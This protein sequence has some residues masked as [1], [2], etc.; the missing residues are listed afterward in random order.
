MQKIRNN[1]DDTFENSTVKSSEP[2]EPTSEVDS[3]PLSVGQ[4][5]PQ[6]PEAVSQYQE[7]LRGAYDSATGYNPVDEIRYTAGPAPG[8]NSNPSLAGLNSA[9]ASNVSSPVA[10]VEDRVTDDVYTGFFQNAANGYI[11][12]TNLLRSPVIIFPPLDT[13]TQR[14]RLQDLYRKLERAIE[15]TRKRLSD[16]PRIPETEGYDIFENSIDTIEALVKQARNETLLI[17]R[18]AEA[19]PEAQSLLAFIRSVSMIMNGSISSSRMFIIFYQS[20]ACD[21]EKSFIG[22]HAYL[23]QANLGLVNALGNCLY[24][25]S[26]EQPTSTDVLCD[27]NFTVVREA[28][29]PALRSHRPIELLDLTLILYPEVA[30]LQE[31]LFNVRSLTAHEVQ[32][33]LA[34]LQ[35]TIIRLSPATLLPVLTNMA[36]KASHDSAAQQ[37]LN[38]AHQ[39]TIKL[40]ASADSINFSISSIDVANPG[41][42]TRELLIQ[43]CIG[44]GSSL[45]Q[46]L[47]KLLDLSLHR[48]VPKPNT[49]SRSILERD[50]AIGP[51]VSDP[52]A[53]STDSTDEAN[54]GTSLGHE[55]HGGTPCAPTTALGS[56]V[57]ELIGKFRNITFNFAQILKEVAGELVSICDNQAEAI[58]SRNPILLKRTLDL[59]KTLRDAADEADMQI[60]ATIAAA[61]KEALEE[62]RVCAL[63]SALRDEL[64]VVFN[65]ASTLTKA[66]IRVNPQAIYVR[67]LTITFKLDRHCKLLL[68]NTFIIIGNGLAD[69]SDGTNNASNITYKSSRVEDTENLGVIVNVLPDH[70][71]TAIGGDVLN[72]PF[73]SFQA[74]IYVLEQELTAACTA[75]ANLN[76]HPT[77]D[78]RIMLAEW[79][80]I[81]KKMDSVLEEYRKHA[82][83]INHPEDRRAFIATL[84]TLS[85]GLAND[86]EIISNV[87]VDV[88]NYDP[89]RIHTI[90]VDTCNRLRKTLGDIIKRLR[91]L[92]RQEGG[93]YLPAT[94]GSASLSKANDPGRAVS[95]DLGL[96]ATASVSG[97]GGTTGPDNMNAWWR[98][99][100]RLC[101]WC[102]GNT[103]DT[104]IS[105]E[106]LSMLFSKFRGISSKRYKELVRAR[107]SLSKASVHLGTRA[108]SLKATT[109]ILLNTVLISY[110][111]I[112]AL[113][114][115]AIA[116]P[117]AQQL[118]HVLMGQLQESQGGLYSMQAIIDALDD[119]EVGND[120][121][122]Y[123]HKSLVADCSRIIELV[124]QTDGKLM[125]LSGNSAMGT[126]GTIDNEAA[127]SG[128]AA[129]DTALAI[130][131]PVQTLSPDLSAQLMSFKDTVRERA[132]SM[133][134]LRMLLDKILNRPLA[135]VG[136]MLTELRETIEELVLI[137]Q[138]TDLQAQ[139]S[140]IN[141]GAGADTE[142]SQLIFAVREHLSALSV[143]ID[144]A[145]ELL[146]IIQPEEIDRGYDL[147]L[148]EEIISYL[149]SS[150]TGS[151]EQT[152]S[153][154][155]DLSGP[156]DLS[157]LDVLPAP[158][159]PG[160]TV[161]STTPE[162]LPEAADTLEAT[163]SGDAASS[164]ASGAPSSSR[165][166][167]V[168]SGSGTASNTGATGTASG[169]GAASGSG[170]SGGDGSRPP[171][172]GAPGSYGYAGPST[173]TISPVI[174]ILLKFRKLARA[175]AQKLGG[176]RGELAYYI[177]GARTADIEAMAPKL[178]KIIREL[179]VELIGAASHADRQSGDLFGS[180]DLVGVREPAARA[181]AT[182]LYSMLCNAIRQ[183]LTLARTTEQ[184]SRDG[185]QPGSIDPVAL[186]ADLD[187][188]ILH[189]L[190]L[191]GTEDLALSDET[192]PIPGS[193]HVPGTSSGSGT[194]AVVP[195][196]IGSSAN[197][198][199]A[200]VRNY[201]RGIV[202]G[203]RGGSLDTFIA[204]FADLQPSEG[205]TMSEE[206]FLAAS[207]LAYLLTYEIIVG[208]EE[209]LESLE[210]V[211]AQ[212]MFQEFIGEINRLANIVSETEERFRYARVNDE[213]ARA[214]GLSIS[215]IISSTIQRLV[216]LSSAASVSA[217]EEPALIPGNTHVPGTSSSYGAAVVDVSES[218]VGCQ[219]Q[220]MRFISIILDLCEDEY[221]GQA[222]KDLS[223]LI[224]CPPS[225]LQNMRSRLR[226]LLVNLSEVLQ[227]ALREAR[228]YTEHLTD[229]EAQQMT[230]AVISEIETLIGTLEEMENLVNNIDLSPHQRNLTALLG[231]TGTPLNNRLT[232]TRDRLR[233]LMGS[234]PRTSSRA[235]ISSSWWYRWRLC[236]GTPPNPHPIDTTNASDTAASLEELGRYITNAVMSI[237]ITHSA[238]SSYPDSSK[239]ASIQRSMRRLAL[240]LHSYLELFQGTLSR[241]DAVA[242]P[243]SY[244]QLL[245]IIQE[246]ES[247]SAVV[248]PLVEQL[249]NVAVEAPGSQA[250]TTHT[251]ITE[252]CNS[253]SNT[254]EDT[255]NRLLAL[256][257]QG[258][259]PS[260]VTVLPPV[261]TNTPE[262]LPGTEAS[263]P[264]EAAS[265]STRVA[266]SVDA[267]SPGSSSEEIPEATAE[268]DSD[269]NPPSSPSGDEN[270]G[271]DAS[272]GSS[273]DD[274]TRRLH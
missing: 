213:L 128:S 230:A 167:G 163:G 218:G 28:F 57:C 166:T 226:N 268:Q 232:Q 149:S 90:M 173:N 12:S 224:E 43:A 267:S 74:L 53:A 108:S 264:H 59:M 36:T 27:D 165:G 40:G 11:G 156:E 252:I 5:H 136:N 186:I 62:E 256:T 228:E 231:S 77:T 15:E 69:A 219:A 137:M 152:I 212:Q 38:N 164:S 81:K 148:S 101:A 175:L 274:A 216:E 198:S 45:Q 158:A 272:G 239:L 75:L 113:H 79:E 168:N 169:A 103:R 227:D 31:P 206:L 209:Y 248:H 185:S 18:N 121:V 262:V 66:L 130:S 235:G 16:I 114:A 37:L 85:A 91:T 144:N 210:D 241:T 104:E 52:I 251:L 73:L 8:S 23:M 261:T 98:G 253:L 225:S 250:E 39:E 21:P 243:D 140:L 30:A 99:W 182:A 138:A 117:E 56:E 46:T 116:S 6:L 88:E 110:L 24:K 265:A 201:I 70:D 127:D 134:R 111:Q 238:P 188:H 93:S 247:I 76:S 266:P 263:G 246:I 142:V 42:A 181:E 78:F 221:L 245:G 197:D 107:S 157:Y 254:I 105:T 122:V 146:D 199:V 51:N 258:S 176:V 123:L 150:L 233:E 125:A 50:Y 2:R 34:Q 208:Y 33:M 115:E 126:L 67:L 87:A 229:P 97:Y 48:A 200:K 242:D 271:P 109:S 270:T 214:A 3:M 112:N 184:L 65:V 82:E 223:Q 100:L 102:A 118:L 211:A 131:T 160:G 84:N 217:P 240:H 1:I 249:D 63:C 189:L 20:L 22:P 145:T 255:R 94:P 4:D 222:K 60:N 35:S 147:E 161:L 237:H 195:S 72:A 61:S 180:D 202:L 192:A 7:D 143:S 95:S 153:L 89:E 141:I 174:A 220:M 177:D 129:N 139:T 86:V 162:R 26:G 9:A 204:S 133:R 196:G 178:L 190:M 47:G 119:I 80:G 155:L 234:R 215:S 49:V 183:V 172:G 54:P 273:S 244:Q 58:E 120:Q 259:G 32:A 64:R 19:D 135:E 17:Y 25:L 13:N 41:P 269:D 187:Q 194:A 151:L 124:V 68:R 159:T 29:R 257:A 106:A 71:V 207:D 14:V 55:V 193:S 205:M 44:L 236:L 83:T 10:R 96:G 260:P 92:D 132:R 203:G 179:M 154:L 170:T 191:S 171:G